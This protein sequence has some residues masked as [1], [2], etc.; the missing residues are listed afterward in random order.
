MA[1]I[2]LGIALAIGITSA[3][4]ASGYTAFSALP[5]IPLFAL[6][7]WLDRIPRRELGLTGGTA[8]GYMLAL[9]HPIVVMGILAGLAQASGALD[10]SGFDGAKAARNVAIVAG[11]TFVMAIITEEGFFRGWLWAGFAR[12]G[13]TPVPVLLATTLAFVAWH[14]PFVFLSDEFHFAPAHIPLFFANATLIGLV[15]GLLRLGSGSILVASAGHGLWNGL[16]YVLF[17]VGSEVGA[18]GIQDVGTFGPEVGLYAIGLNAAFA[19]LLWWL[20]RD[21]LASRT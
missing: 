21:R 19:A 17:G 11:A 13:F 12:R 7:A 5:L 20:Y 18:L 1:L 10:L 4:D 14:L 6:F 9:A 2:W 15:W 3:M 16:T 8:S